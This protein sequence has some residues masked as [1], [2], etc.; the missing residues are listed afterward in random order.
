MP[1]RLGRPCQLCPAPGRAPIPLLPRVQSQ[2]A[3]AC[4]R[5]TDQG[6]KE[7]AKYFQVGAA[8]MLSGAKRGNVGLGRLPRP[9]CEACLTGAAHAGGGGAPLRWAGCRGGRAG[10][11]AA[12]CSPAMHH[13]CPLWTAPAAGGHGLPGGGSPWAHAFE[14]DA[15]PPR[16][17]PGPAR[18]SRRA[19]LATC[20]T[21]R[22]SRWSRRGRWTSPPRQPPCWRS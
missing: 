10:C 20:G 3:L 14:L 19:A 7:S 18:R 2:M 15:A 8:H 12:A 22:A 5:K 9:C 6:L 1:R 11:L 13:R 17:A 21:W 16:A 4:D